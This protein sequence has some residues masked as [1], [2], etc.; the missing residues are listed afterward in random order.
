MTLF[1]TLL[2]SHLLAAAPDVQPVVLATAPAA[3]APAA[4]ERGASLA[5][6]EPPRTKSFNLLIGGLELLG[7]LIGGYAGVVAG[8]AINF[9]LGGVNIP[10]DGNDLLLVAALP[11]ILAASCGWVLGLLDFSQ[12]TLVGSLLSAALG[13]VVGEIAGLGIGYLIG[14]GLAPGDLG[15]SASIAVLIA[16]AFSALGAV[17]F[18]EWLKPGAVAATASVMPVRDGRGLVGFVPA[19]AV[20]F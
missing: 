18:M 3:A 6:R 20:R 8:V 19:V 11:A 5:N 13:A 14:R 10:P 2:A 16:P 4:E 9:P 15:G 1:A 12:R 7:A 17:F